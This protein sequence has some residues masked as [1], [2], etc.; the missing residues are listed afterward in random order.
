MF[1]TTMSEIGPQIT[2]LQVN[3]QIIVIPITVGDFQQRI[4]EM[5]DFQL[6]SDKIP[7]Q[8]KIE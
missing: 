8:G 7:G 1:R 6:L 5:G 4:L 2:E 3:F